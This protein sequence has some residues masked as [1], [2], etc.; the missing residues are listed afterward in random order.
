MRIPSLLLFFYLIC[1]VINAQVITATVYDSDTKEPIIGASVYYD[2]T[3]IGTATN[4]NGQFKIDYK[5]YLNAPIVIS[6]I[7]YTTVLHNKDDLQQM[8]KVF[9]KPS[10]T[11]MPEL[12]FKADTWSREKKLR[13]F[14]AEFLGRSKGASL[15]RIVNEKDIQLV[16]NP[17]NK[18]LRAYCDEPIIIRNKYLGYDITYNM[19]DFFVEF[20]YTPD[21]IRITKEVYYAGTSFFSE[22]GKPTKKKY[23]EARLNEFEGS[24]L[25]F[26][27]TLAGR[28]LSDSKYEIFYDT[29]KVEPEKYLA[30]ENQKIHKKV[31]MPINKLTVLYDRTSQSIIQLDTTEKHFFVNDY[32]IHFPADKLK[33]GGDFGVQRISSMLPKDYNL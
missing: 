5:V 15:C 3:T 12:V 22:I 9:L 10:A 31:T 14:K 6:F 28:N 18:I 17:V 21:L 23:V 7:G 30:I 33:F 11:K 26:F 19:V 27:R 29:L 4:A 25:E 13:I 24:K 2:G 32:G 20:T 1:G 16:Y 8:D